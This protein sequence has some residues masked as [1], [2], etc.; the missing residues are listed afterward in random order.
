LV[1]ILSRG[2]SYNE[3]DGTIIGAWEGASPH[4]CIVDE[5]FQLVRAG[6][7]QFIRLP[8]PEKLHT[9]VS[10]PIRVDLG[11]VDRPAVG[12]APRRETKEVTWEGTLQEA[13]ELGRALTAAPKTG[14]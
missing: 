7:S 14:Q 5:R 13:A 8:L 4:D 12:T 10:G 3:K 6:Q 9:K 11:V 2:I 1:C